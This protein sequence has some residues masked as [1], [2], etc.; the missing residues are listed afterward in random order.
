[1]VENLAAST[2]SNHY[3]ACKKPAKFLFNLDLAADDN[4]QGILSAAKKVRPGRRGLSAFPKWLLQV[5][6]EYLNSEVFEPLEEASSNII[7]TKLFILVLLNTGRRV[8]EISAIIKDYLRQ[9][10]DVVFI[11][12][13]QG[14]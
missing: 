8:G 13:F 14:F 3:Y 11:F 2:V 12:G 10:G 7:R 5:L 6:L 1:M 9:K 4:I